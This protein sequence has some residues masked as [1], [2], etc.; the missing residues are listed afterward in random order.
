MRGIS[1]SEFEAVD[2]ARLYWRRLGRRFRNLFIVLA[3]TALVFLLF[4]VPHA[5]FGNYTYP[6]YIR[7][8]P[9][10]ASQ[11]LTAWYL[12][13]TGWKHVKREDYGPL[14][15]ILFIPLADC[16]NNEAST[17]TPDQQG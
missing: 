4:G 8:R 17:T 9:P 7:K 10:E 14:T 16:L 11:K 6:S 15:F 1:I 3:A 13:V 5:Q 12:S 2:P